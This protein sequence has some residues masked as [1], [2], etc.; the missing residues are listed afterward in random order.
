MSPDIVIELKAE[1]KTLS[2][3][4][5]KLSGIMETLIRIEERLINQKDD[6]DGFGKRLNHFDA[7]LREAEQLAVVNKSKGDTTS[8]W[9]ER[10]IWAVLASAL[11][12]AVAYLK[13]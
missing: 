7:R 8:Q 9:V 5:S 3:E 1:V 13:K 2:A 11:A 4:V 12:A 10:G 6:V